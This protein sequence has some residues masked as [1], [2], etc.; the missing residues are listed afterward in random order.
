MKESEINNAAEKHLSDHPDNAECGNQEKQQQTDD[1]LRCY[2][3][4]QL[5]KSRDL[6]GST[7]SKILDKDRFEDVGFFEFMTRELF[8]MSISIKYRS[9][10]SCKVFSADPLDEK[11]RKA[12]AVCDMRCVNITEDIGKFMEVL[13]KDVLSG[14]MEDEDMYFADYEFEELAKSFDLA[15]LRRDYLIMEA[16]RYLPRSQKR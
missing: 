8:R 15:I 6:A 13:S 4:D 7:M 5:M 16:E 11:I 14:K 2:F 9:Y 12:L 1:D 3:H 10:D